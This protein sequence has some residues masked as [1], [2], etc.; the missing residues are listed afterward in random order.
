YMI[1]DDA[2]NLE[3]LYWGDR[4]AA[5]HAFVLDRPP[6]NR[7]ERWIKWQASD[8]N[9]FAVA[10][11]ALLIS[12]AVGI[13]S[14]GGTAFQSWVAWKAWKEPVASDDTEV[15]ADLRELAELVRLRRLR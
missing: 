11:V 5:L 2:D 9:I 8:S 15:V 4:L 7:F 1:F 10:L 14:L 12:N 3:Y 6:R 13:L